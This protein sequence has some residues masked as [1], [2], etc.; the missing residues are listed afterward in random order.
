MTKFNSLGFEIGYQKAQPCGTENVLFI[1]GNLASKEWWYPGM[2]VMQRQ[3]GQGTVIAADWRGYG[4]ST[5]LIDASDIDFTTFA[6][7]FV[8][9]LES[10]GL[11]EVNV[12][13]HSTGGLIAMLAVLEKPQLF[14][15]LILL[16]S[17]GATGLELQLPKNQVLAHFQTMSENRDYALATLAATIKD[18]DPQS[19]S[20]QKLFEITW[21][22]DKVMFQG[23]IDVL[24]DQIDI[25]ERMSEIRLPTLILHGDQDM[26]LP[27]STAESLQKWLPQ[28]QLKVM[29][30][31]GHSMNI[32]NPEQMVSEFSQFWAALS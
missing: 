21:N 19:P 3:P 4:D 2:E 9:L 26:V 10:E 32:E 29:T 24:S 1:H 22:C 5:G 16:D 17:V 14:K 25:T 31:Q 7:D 27:L 12:V 30:G 23:V 6:Q 11:T 15:S 18:C 28:A 20:F 13:G 8:R